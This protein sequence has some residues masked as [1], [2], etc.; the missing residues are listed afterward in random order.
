M[1]SFEEELKEE[2]EKDTNRKVTQHARETKR[3][4]HKR[5]IKR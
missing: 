2:L 1:N 3:W 5:Q 4:K